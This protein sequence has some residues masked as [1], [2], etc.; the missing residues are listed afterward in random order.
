MILLSILS[1]FY[2]YIFTCMKCACAN[3][4]DISMKIRILRSCIHNQFF[5]KKWK[6]FGSC[7]LLQ[8]NY[9]QHN[10]QPKRIY[11]KFE[12]RPSDRSINIRKFESITDL[13][14]YVLPTY[15][16]FIPQRGR[17]ISSRVSFSTIPV[18]FI[19]TNLWNFLKRRTE[20]LTND[21]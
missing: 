9:R 16:S 1:R 5:R 20:I 4:L 10:L 8:G 19:P 15:T 18:T 3:I 2:L 14:A 12:R 21:T 17:S 13:P 6:L 7:L 11:D